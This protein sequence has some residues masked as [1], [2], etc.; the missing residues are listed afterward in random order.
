[1]RN[2]LIALIICIAN[3]SCAQPYN[4][5]IEQID[6]RTGL[7]KGWG[8]GNVINGALPKDKTLSCYKVDSTIKQQGKYSLLVDWP[9][10]CRDWTPTNY[11]IN[12]I[13][14]GKKIKLTGFVKTENV[15]GVGAGLWMRLDGEA[16]ENKGFDNMMKRAIKG[17]T[18]WT[19]YTIELDYDM[20]EVKRVVVGGLITGTGKMWIDNLHITID[21]KD[22]AELPAYVPQ[23]KYKA[24]NDLAF[25]NGSGIEKITLSDEKIKTLTNLGMLWGFIKYYHANVNSGDYNMDAALF[26]LLPKVLSATNTSEANAAMERWVDDFGKPAICKKCSDPK[27][28][29]TI[30]LTPDYGYLFT[31]GNFPATLTGKLDY[32]KH[33][34]S[35]NEESYY[36]EAGPGV[37]NPVFKHE[38]SYSNT[39]Y[40]DAGTR[41]LAL[42]RYWNMVQYFFP[43]KH[44]IGEDWN[45]VL[46]EFIP[47]FCNAADSQAYQVACLKLIARIHD[48][49]AN[50]WSGGIALAK[51][52]GDY[53]APFI[54]TFIEDK[55]V[56]TGYQIINTELTDKIKIG[57]VI[58]RIDG[59]SVDEL[60]KK[61]LPLTP[62]SNYE[63]QLRDM[64]T[65]RGYLLR[66]NKQNAEL[67]IQRD[68]HNTDVTLTR[69]PVDLI[70]R[71]TTDTIGYKMLPDNIGYMYPA[72][73]NDN[74]L[75]K[76]KE[77]FENTKGFVI[78][79]RCYPSVFMTF[80]YADWLKPASSPFVTFTAG[81][82][83]YPGYFDIVEG[84]ENGK[85]NK[86]YYKGKVVIIVNAETQ[87]SA[88]YQTMAL[89]T[90]PKVTVIGSTTAGADGNVSQIL[91]PGGLSTMFSG[92]GILYPDGTESQRK[93]VKIDKVVKPTIKGIKEGRDELMEEAL[94]II[95][96]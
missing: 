67:T 80:S 44:L 69:I 74:D 33:N 87:S 35:G 34:R 14:K 82:M 72:L 3:M 20:D 2:L 5:D 60:V 58:E 95:N 84:P 61:Y 62:A 48:T 94:R 31:A 83:D 71:K 55:L 89:C 16:N 90:A 96:G 13:F 91:L 18:D 79:M 21:G 38:M 76:I 56:V 15:N 93:G 64:P 11:V 51:M 75:P 24:G 46:T 53:A 59:Q 25:I 66:S 8:M 32:I 92:I 49:H 81:R 39:T 6:A 47:E 77:Q 28:S 86:N 26:R 41:L 9:E 4:L 23:S 70:G 63:T 12:K 30:K 10:G 29:S 40:P 54:A 22:I 50:I 65:Y 36:I 45:K 7:P 1:M 85:K 52:K 88:E 43:D 17:T 73:L 78:D 37:G 27:P 19:E 68:G 57:D 42:Y